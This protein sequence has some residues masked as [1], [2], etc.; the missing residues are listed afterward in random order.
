MYS[1]DRECHIMEVCK[2]WVKSDKNTHTLSLNSLCLNSLYS[3]TAIQ[4][5]SYTAIQLYSYTAIPIPFKGESGPGRTDGPDGPGGN[6]PLNI[7][8]TLHITAS[9]KQR[10]R[11][12]ERQRD[13]L[14]TNIFLDCSCLIFLF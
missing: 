3:Y 10:Y 2:F 6:L 5:Y 9:N 14:L 1:N 7:T 4:L 13:R 11:E 8:A 12:I